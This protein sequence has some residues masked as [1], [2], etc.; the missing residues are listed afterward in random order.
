VR[1]HELR[2]RAEAEADTRMG[3]SEDRY[4]KGFDFRDTLSKTGLEENIS[5]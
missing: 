1:E 5:G 4:A 3:D 2:S